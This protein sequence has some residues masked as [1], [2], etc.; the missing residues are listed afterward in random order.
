MGLCGVWGEVQ[1]PSGAGS[2]ASP[3]A[4]QKGCV[5]RF[6]RWTG[7]WPEDSEG[8]EGSEGSEGFGGALTGAL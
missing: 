7:L 8:T 2:A 4:A 5:K 1:R 3:Q 6:L